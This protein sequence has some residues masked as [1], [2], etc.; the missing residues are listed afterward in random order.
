MA[1]ECR[2]H[3]GRVGTVVDELDAIAIDLGTGPHQSPPILAA[4][5]FGTVSGLVIRRIPERTPSPRASAP[6][7]RPP[8]VP[9]GLPTK[10][11]RRLVEGGMN[12]ERRI[13]PGHAR[14]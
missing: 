6:P 1:L 10:S 12:D 3:R 5:E 4:L 13:V 2:D 9:I 8:G 11:A 7:P 14:N